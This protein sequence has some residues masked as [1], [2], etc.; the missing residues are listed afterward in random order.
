VTNL[1]QIKRVTSLC[2]ASLPDAFVADLEREPD[3]DGQF[4]VGV[5]FAIQQVREL[6][7]AGVPGIHFYVLNKSQATSEVLEATVVRGLP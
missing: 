6:I 1:P 4:K 2:G 7:Q 5:A 3:A